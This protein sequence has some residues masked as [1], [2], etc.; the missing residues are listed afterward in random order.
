[1]PQRPV[2]S[3]LLLLVL[4]TL[5][6]PTLSERPAQ[7]RLDAEVWRQVQQ[8]HAKLFAGPGKFSAK[9]KNL[10]L[11]LEDGEKRSWKLIVE[12]LVKEAEFWVLRQKAVREKELQIDEVQSKPMAK[13]YP[14]EQKNLVKWKEELDKLERAARGE[15]ETLNDLTA[16][17]A[18]G[19]EALRKN[20]FNRAKGPVGWSV[21]A[22][23]ARVAAVRPDEKLSFEY[24][25]KVLTGDKDP[26]VRMSA[27][28]ALREVAA[29]AED[30]PSGDGA[31]DGVDAA[32]GL[33]LGRLGDKDWG[34]Q[35]LAVR[36][37]KARQ[38]SSAVPHLINALAFASPRV[39][40]AIG[41]VLCDLTGENF[42]PYADVWSKWWADH[43]EEYE[44]KERVKG[45][46]NARPPSDAHFYGLPLK[47]DRILFIID[48]S[49]SMKLPTKNTNPAEKWK[50]P[51][52]P[53]TPGDNDA[54]PPPP[55][56]EEILSGPKIDVAKHELKKAI[57]KLPPSS[58]F[59]IIAFN[60][61]VFKWRDTMQ[62]ADE[63]TKKEAL[64]WVRA[65]EPKGIT[66]IDG[67][68]RLA[69]RMAGL[70]SFDKA[71]P[72]V[73][74][75]TMY[76]LSDGAPTTDDISDVDS[77]G[78]VK[79]MDNEIILEHVRGWNRHNRIVIHC[80]GVDMQAGIELLQILAMENGGKYVDR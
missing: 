67:A 31:A 35:L 59:N 14:E 40:E 46:K 73:N 68:L 21:R 79:L 17:V 52:G 65:L 20:L 45:G 62:K 26:R 77:Q 54:P 32:E 63:K 13:R 28:E 2:R 70:A 12:G 60:T 24:L 58:M 27:L 39:S 44:S 42:D 57:E 72:E 51:E 53:T 6:L 50:P 71:Y 64:K 49:S 76:L 16:A 38:M 9:A 23:A 29:A 5:L 43:K 61:G 36:I 7:A 37:V 33:I 18:G 11:L 19:P 10:A 25:T 3:I 69:F 47:S 34:V 80:I 56:P 74:I 4:G 55:P 30:P 48:T 1:M 15:L 75:D 78:H 66:Y 22:A 8:D 41:D